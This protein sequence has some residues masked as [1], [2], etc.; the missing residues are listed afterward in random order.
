VTG[1]FPRRS[2]LVVFGLQLVGKGNVWWAEKASWFRNPPVTAVHPTQG[3]IE[4]R[5]RFGELAKEAKA[6]G[7]VGTRTSPKL[8]TRLGKYLVGSAAYIAD[9]M[10]GYRAPNALRPEEWPSRL[11]RTYRTLEELKAMLAR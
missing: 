8:S 10:A 3:Q 11:K 9:N 6:R 4:V 2:E 7:E 1:A 5:V